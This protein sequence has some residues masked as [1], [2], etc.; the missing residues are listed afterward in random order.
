MATHDCP[1]YGAATNDELKMGCW[2]EHKDGS[3]ILV[4]GTEN[5][6]VVYSI[7]DMDKKPIIEYRDS[8]K[9]TAFKKQ[10]S[11]GTDAGWVWHNRTA[12]PWD[13]I[14]DK[15]GQ[16]GTRHASAVDL[17]TAAERVRRSRELHTGE[18]VDLEA[19]ETRMDRLGEKAEAIIKRVQR[20]ISRLPKGK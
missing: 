15:G 14:I 17:M 18:P 3:L 9:E 5:G 10:F 12:F 16:D 13:R 7:F 6:V 1:G 4:E 11:W 8:M 2:S 19:V 20:A